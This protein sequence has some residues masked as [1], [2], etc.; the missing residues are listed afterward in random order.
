[1]IAQEYLS[2]AEVELWKRL[3]TEPDFANSMDAARL[4]LP[5]PNLS[6]AHPCARPCAALVSQP[7]SV[8]QHQ[9]QPFYSGFKRQPR[10]R[11]D[12][13]KRLC[14]SPPPEASTGMR[15]ASCD[16]PGSPRWDALKREL[17]AFHLET[18]KLLRT[19][20]ELSERLIGYSSTTQS[21]AEANGLIRSLLQKLRGE[22]PKSETSEKGPKANSD[23]DQVMVIHRR[24]RNHRGSQTQLLKRW[25][26]EH[27]LEPYPSYEEKM[28]LA[29]ETN[30]QIQQ[31]ENW[32]TNQR[33]RHWNTHTS[34]AAKT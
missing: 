15:M 31:I 17:D 6:C 1:M 11:V 33:K 30:L 28:Q 13:C 2:E 8:G 7:H 27:I 24:K 34:K 26:Y 14:D 10:D 18:L 4:S 21:M 29:Q 9:S 23:P 32:F 22:V 5:A 16:E 3:N 19:G 25:F 20:T 12:E